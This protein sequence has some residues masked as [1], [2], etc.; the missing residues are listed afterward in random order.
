[1]FNFKHVSDAGFG[2]TL[3]IR[4]CGPCAA[5]Q[6]TNTPILPPMSTTV[7]FGRSSKPG[8]TYRPCLKISHLMCLAIGLIDL[9]VKWHTVPLGSPNCSLLIPHP[10]RVRTFTDPV[11]LLSY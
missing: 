3:T 4:P 9:D 8:R 5:A 7:S 1:M 11:P 2:S 10:S 6:R